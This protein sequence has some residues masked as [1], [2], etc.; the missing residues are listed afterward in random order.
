M[1]IEIG[2]RF[3]VGLTKDTVENKEGNKVG[4]VVKGVV[5]FGNVGK[6]GEVGVLG[7]DKLS[8]IVA[9]GVVAREEKFNRS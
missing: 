2:S 4:K 5:N 8:F 1:F 7:K 3:D 9:L 6:F